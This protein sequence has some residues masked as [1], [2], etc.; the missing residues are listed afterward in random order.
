MKKIILLLLIISLSNCSLNKVI[1]K[2]AANFLDDGTTVLYR[3]SDLE[4]AEH[5]LANNLK[6]VEMLLEKDPDNEK[7]N[8]TAAQG[9]GAY[10]M[11]FVE[12]TDPE[13]ASHLYLR[14]VNFG[15]QAL[16]KNKKFS[17][18][19][20][21]KE[22]EDILQTYQKGEVPSLFWTGYNWGLFVMQNL[23]KTENL[24]NLAKIEKIMNRCLELDESYY[25]YSVDI[26]YG[27]YYGARPRM[28]GG[29]PEKS[30]A[31]FQKNIEMN[32]GNILI[33][34]LFYARYYALQNYDEPLFDKLLEEIIN[35]DLE[36]NPDYRL[37]NAIAQKKA[38]TLK[39]KKEKLF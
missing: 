24:L 18:E 3:E 4:I 2:S 23:D 21:L 35:F 37:L 13:R 26:F 31:F 1:V 10:A 25:F 32:D 22:L 28:L 34:K 19:T 17:M 38:M 16:P 15:L 33:G 29:N 6:T 8:I 12:D 27:A 9:Y 11:A 39:N 14:G 20:N 5:F 7:L 30:Q 36:K